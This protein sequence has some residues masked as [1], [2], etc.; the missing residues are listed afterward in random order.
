MEYDEICHLF[1]IKTEFLQNTDNV[2]KLT[3]NEFLFVSNQLVLRYLLLMHVICCCL[4]T[5]T[6]SNTN[7]QSWHSH[8]D[9]IWNEHDKNNLFKWP[10]QVCPQWITAV[11]WNAALGILLWTSFAGWKLLPSSEFPPRAGH[12][13]L[14]LTAHFWQ[15]TQHLLHPPPPFCF[16]Q[17]QQAFRNEM[18]I[19][20]WWWYTALYVAPG[21][22][23][24]C[25][26]RCKI[27]TDVFAEWVC[28]ILEWL[29]V[30]KKVAAR[31]HRT[32]LPEGALHFSLQLAT[33]GE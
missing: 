20:G 14:C 21:T 32:S 6:I 31:H 24:F 12:Q 9:F 13:R 7:L 29:C 33:A 18:T 1:P 26:N 2:K 4:I 27:K 30:G 23:L 10:V 22:Y 8:T 25:Q 15:G 5:I 3:C 19:T 16:N 28:E 17:A 11:T